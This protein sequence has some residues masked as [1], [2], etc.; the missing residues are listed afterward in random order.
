MRCASILL[1][2]ML[3]CSC[4]WHEGAFDIDDRKAWRAHVNEKCRT[5][6]NW[7]IS[8]ADLMRYVYYHIE[9]TGWIDIR[10]IIWNGATSRRGHIAM[11]VV[12]YDN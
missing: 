4:A 10:V 8:D 1:L 2:C 7:G 6:R 12:Y 5:F 3:L 11:V 9:G